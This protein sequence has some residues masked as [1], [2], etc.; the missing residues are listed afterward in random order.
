VDI[1]AELRPY[2]EAVNRALEDVLPR[3]P[4]REYFRRVARIG[5][6]LD[7]ESLREVLS[8]PVWDLLDRGGKRWRPVLGLLTYGA[9]GG[10][11]EDV[12]RLMVIPELIHNGTLIVDDVEDG[13]DYR[14]GRPCIHKIYGEDI[15]INAGNT[16]YY[17]P[18]AHIIAE[19][20][21]PPE[22]QLTLLKIYI[23]EM[24]KL[25]IGQALDIAWH[26]SIGDIPNE[27]GYLTMC[28]LKTGSLARMPVRMACALARADPAVEEGLSR[29]SSSIAVAF[30]IQDDLLNLVGD[31][32]LYGKEI[33]GDIREG[34]R[35]LMVIHALR[36]LPRERAARLLE[37]LGMRAS[38]RSLLAEGIELIK[39]SGAIEYSRAVAERL[40]SESW[41]AVQPYLREGRA[42]ELLRGLA[43]YLIRRS[44]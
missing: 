14:R 13:S 30:Q 5:G 11:W 34:K 10:R 29:F 19:H 1:E 9:L 35:T 20:Q 37:I 2:V 15:A 44:R 6:E 38:D 32:A 26:R 12:V 24:L 27:E 25:S 4:G 36:N 17:L 28:D 16:L 39:E 3:T 42:A 18:V 21:L 40:V 43:E 23:G 33:G 8:R 22:T 7:V 41:S 31:E